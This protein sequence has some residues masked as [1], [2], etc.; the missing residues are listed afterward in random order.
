MAKCDYC[1][2]NIDSLPW[3]CKRCGKTFCDSHRLSETLYCSGVKKKNFLEPLTKR[4]IHKPKDY[5][6]ESNEIEYEMYIPGR[7]KYSTHHSSLGHFNFKDFLR[8]Y[9]YFRI[10]GD[11][12]PHLM[13][14]LLIF[15]IGVV[16]NYV[17]YHIFSLN[18]LFI[19]GVNEWLRVL[20]ST[21][22][23]GL[24]NTYNS[25]YLIINGIY[26]AY[27]YYGFV[28]VLYNTITNLDD[29]DTWVMW[30]WFALIIYAVL[31]FFPQIV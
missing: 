9:I 13:Q 16:L 3:A 12:K 30:G 17:Y 20:T 1:R 15:I 7:K 23:Y 22:N 11:V 19:G 6:L 18:Y 8:R 25:F 28:L 4:T 26:Y 14:F 29:T 2:G 5:K 24:W 31:Y 10:Q 21:L 27:F